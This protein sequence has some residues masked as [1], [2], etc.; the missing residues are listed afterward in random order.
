[1]PLFLEYTKIVNIYVVNIA[2]FYLFIIYNI[3]YY[4]L[5]HDTLV[6][7][8]NVQVFT[9]HFVYYVYLCSLIFAKLDPFLFSCI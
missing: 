5:A 9:S 4:F 7:V 8:F 2:G 1:M 3:N 6:S